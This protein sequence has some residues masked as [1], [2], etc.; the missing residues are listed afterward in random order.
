MVDLH[1]KSTYVKFYTS[2][3][4]DKQLKLRTAACIYSMEI[5][6]LN[7]TQNLHVFF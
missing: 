1:A 4:I 2:S 6:S 3:Y 7:Y 5:S